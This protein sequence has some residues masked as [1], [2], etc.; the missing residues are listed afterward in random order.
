MKDIL[1]SPSIYQFYQVIGGF[2]SA[3]VRAIQQYLEIKPGQR[4][5]DIGCGP[6]HILAKLPEGTIYDGFDPDQKYIDFANAHFGRYGRFH[7]RMFDMDAA[8]EFGWADVVMMNGVLHHLDDESV[9]ETAP[10][11]QNTLKPGGMFFALDGVYVS[12]QNAVAKWM[13][14]NDRGKFIREEQAHRELLSAA[15]GP[16]EFHVRH[17]MTR[18]P[19]SLIIS[20]YRKASA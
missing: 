16:C 12:G 4:V 5:I 9:G 14:D 17:D 15:F 7:C 8:K 19:Y 1:N 13:L 6:G 20:T 18:I 2:F 11:V 10:I 3:R